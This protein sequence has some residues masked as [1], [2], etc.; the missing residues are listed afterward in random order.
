MVHIVCSSGDFVKSPELCRK[1]T[2]LK[3]RIGKA[4]V[5][6]PLFASLLISFG[7]DRICAAEKLRIGI[8]LHPYYSFVKNIVANRAEVIPL[9]KAG[10][11]VHNYRPQP[12]DI[13]RVMAMDAIVV[14][15]IGHDEFAINII[16]AAWVE[17]R[18]KIIYANKGVASIPVAGTDPEDR[19][20]NS[21]NFVS[22]SS[23]IQQIYNIGDAL[24][25]LDPA[26]AVR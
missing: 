6:I 22:I 12:D 17:N 19:T 26:N 24:A 20:V 23:S 15:G 8:T 21:H 11:N 13:K 16:A 7:N 5:T 9:I 18:I 4:A 2:K 3:C 14:N 25:K 1:M 10:F